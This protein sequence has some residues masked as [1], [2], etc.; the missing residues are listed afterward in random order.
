[1]PSKK[2]QQ[3]SKLSSGNVTREKVIKT[4]VTTSTSGSNGGVNLMPPTPVME[5]SNQ[6]IF[7]F[8]IK[9]NEYYYEYYIIILNTS[10]TRI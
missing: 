9:L 6:G 8:L 5:D 10:Q 2:K 7:L 3:M 4:S 1:M